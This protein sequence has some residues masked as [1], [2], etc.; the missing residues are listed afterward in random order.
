MTT[1]TMDKMLKAYMDAAAVERLKC[2]RPEK[3]T[4]KNTRHG[5]KRFVQWMNERRLKGGL[6]YKDLSDGFPLV[7]VVKPPLIHKYLADLLKAGTRPITAM[8]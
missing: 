3:G 5:V 8:T 7:S 6:E 4:V 1:P 2:G